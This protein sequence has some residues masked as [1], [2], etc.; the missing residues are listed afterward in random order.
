MIFL[1]IY[2]FFLIFD[3]QIVSSNVKTYFMINVLINKNKFVVYIICYILVNMAFK[4]NIAI[5]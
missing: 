3:F 2:I 4:Q 5:I 1:K